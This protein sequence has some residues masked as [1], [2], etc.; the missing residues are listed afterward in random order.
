MIIYKVHGEGKTGALFK[1]PS[2]NKTCYYGFILTGLLVRES[3]SEPFPFINDTL[4]APPAFKS[5]HCLNTEHLYAYC[6]T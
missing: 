4:G 3:A 2:I 1:N 5:P 6:E